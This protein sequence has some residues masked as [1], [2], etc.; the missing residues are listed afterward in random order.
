MHETS[1]TERSSTTENTSRG[2]KRS[3][4]SS[5]ANPGKITIKLTKPTKKR[6]KSADDKKSPTFD[7]SG[8]LLEGEEKYRV[9]CDINYISKCYEALQQHPK[10]FRDLKFD[11]ASPKKKVP[12]TQLHGIK[13]KVYTQNEAG[14]RSR[15]LKCRK[16]AKT[17]RAAKRAAAGGLLLMMLEHYPELNG[18]QKESTNGE[19]NGNS[20][21]NDNNKDNKPAA[22][23]VPLLNAVGILYD[24]HKRDVIQE[25]PAYNAVQNEQW[26]VTCT[27]DIPSTSKD[28]AKD[29]KGQRK[30]IPYSAEAKHTKKKQATMIAA[31]NLLDKLIADGI[32]GCQG[33]LNTYLDPKSKNAQAK[34]GVDGDND[35]EAA[36]YDEGD[37]DDDEQVEQ[38]E[39]AAERKRRAFSA[40]LKN[41]GAEF[42]VPEGYVIK[43]AKS[44]RECK[45]FIDEHG[46]EKMGVYME[47]PDVYKSIIYGLHYFESR[48]N[49]DNMN[50]PMVAGECKVI[51]LA[52]ESGALVLEE[53]NFSSDEPWP[54]V[55]L[56]NLFRDPHAELCGY[57]LNAGEH[58]L[59]FTPEYRHCIA[60]VQTVANGLKSARDTRGAIHMPLADILP[61]WTGKTLSQQIIGGRCVDEKRIKTAVYT[62]AAVLAA[63]HHMCV[64]R[65]AKIRN[66]I[67]TCSIRGFGDLMN[68]LGGRTQLFPVT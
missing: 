41:P 65:D 1:R 46:E 57:K 4:T 68:L 7:S 26:E 11:P 38:T 29:A 44:G 13:A 37:D 52:V 31:K 18:K 19:E 48:V 53:P 59:G 35:E 40:W 54:P 62:A 58:A 61:R 64:E 66:Q 30:V 5:E 8:V 33:M 23:E 28:D 15:K 36:G 47:S 14:E 32:K 21:S 24:L 25:K 6:K 55:S 20:N 17:K 10:V 60:D 2:T 39:Q 42:R 49:D 56:M 16:H 34:Q 3:R 63:Y 27:V 43:V 51:A 45:D 50:I 67:G 9:E 12:L 22:L